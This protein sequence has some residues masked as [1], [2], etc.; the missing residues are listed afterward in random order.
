MSDLCGRRLAGRTTAL[1]VELNRV[2]GPPGILLPA[3]SMRLAKRLLGHDT[4]RVFVCHDQSGGVRK[5]RS[6]WLQHIARVRGRKSWRETVKM[7]SMIIDIIAGITIGGL[8]S[9]RSPY[10][11]SSSAAAC[12]A[13]ALICSSS[14]RC[15]S[16]S[17]SADICS[18]RI[19]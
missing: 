14:R 15:V 4:P 5:F 3:E 17:H 19:S 1:Y 8:T 6:E 11:S 10:F 12:A 13:A 9:R 16:S 7:V 2:V 18:G